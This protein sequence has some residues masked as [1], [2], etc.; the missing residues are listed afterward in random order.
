MQRLNI[1]G[2]AFFSQEDVQLASLIPNIKD[3]ELDALETVLPLESSDYTVRKVEDNLAI[4]RGQTDDKVQAFLTHLI[5]WTSHRSSRAGL[6]LAAQAGRIYTLRKP[7][8]WFQRLCEN[9]QVRKWLQE[10]IEDGCKV[11]FVVGIHTLFDTST[12]EGLELA[13]EHAGGMSVSAGHVSGL[14]LHGAMN[15]GVSAGASSSRATV[16]RCTVPGEQIFAVRL[17]RVRFRSWAPDV[18]KAHLGKNSYWKMASDNRSFGDDSEEVIEV[19]LE[20]HADGE[21]EFDEPGG[22]V[23]NT[24]DLHII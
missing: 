10:Q 22:F 16:H 21:D 15:A 23:G 8:E 20:E 11:H 3:I 7:T 1:L 17:M 9:D 6:N 12:S 5:K 24:V 18:S 14:P 19:F 2:H 4:L 13:S